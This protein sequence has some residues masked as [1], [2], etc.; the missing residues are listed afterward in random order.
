MWKIVILSILSLVIG[1]Q[2]SY[3]QQ[4]EKYVSY[5]DQAYHVDNFAKAIKAYNIALKQNSTDS[6]ALGKVSECQT[7]LDGVN[8]FN[9]VDYKNAQ[10]KFERFSNNR[11]ASYHLGLIYLKGLTGSKDEN[12]ARNYLNNALSKGYDNAR[13]PLNEIQNN[14]KQSQQKANDDLYTYYIQ[15]GDKKYSSYDYQNAKFYYKKAIELKGSSLSP[16]NSA[17]Y[18]L[19]IIEEIEK[20]KSLFYSGKFE[21]AKKLFRNYKTNGMSLFY[22]GMI[23]QEGRGVPV[24]LPTAKTLYEDSLS[25]G[26]SD[27]AQKIEDI[28]IY[29]KNKQS[30]S[31]SPRQKYTKYFDKGNK[32]YLNSNYSASLSAFQKAL[33]IGGVADFDISDKIEIIN[34]YFSAVS[35]FESGNNKKAVDILE[36]LKSSNNR[37][38]LYLLGKIYT[39]KFSYRK[40][41]EFGIKYLKD[42]EL[43]GDGR[44]TKL[45]EEL[46]IKNSKKKSLNIKKQ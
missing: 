17:K 23:Y 3:A 39:T 45:L 28:N 46:S 20:G 18:N 41:K 13:I 21:E 40:L 42:S 7:L 30:V 33:Q 44:A 4:Y 26:Y 43:L 38:A 10:N 12:R 15:E 36:N 27:S 9:L 19:K 31:L 22:L 29:Y 8:Y 14:D 16:S 32:Y 24:D 6:Y 37:D 1:E 11:V 35:A 25:K 5:G 34:A 2:V